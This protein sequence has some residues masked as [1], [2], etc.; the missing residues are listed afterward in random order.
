LPE[1]K[2]PP[3]HVTATCAHVRSTTRGDSRGEKLVN[4][5]DTASFCHPANE[6]QESAVTTSGVA[7]VTTQHGGTP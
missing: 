7:R 3:T 2:P 1:N 4:Q 6:G 5:N